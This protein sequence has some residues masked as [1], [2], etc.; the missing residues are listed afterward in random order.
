MGEEQ[1]D[2]M[3]YFK[4]ASLAA[5]LVIAATTAEARQCFYKG[6]LYSD[7]AANDL[8]QICDGLTGSWKTG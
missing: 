7:G 1:E 8:G 4:L 6:E 5:C 2:P 3:R